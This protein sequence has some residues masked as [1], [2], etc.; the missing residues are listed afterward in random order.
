MW[1]EIDIP[2]LPAVLR[3]YTHVHHSVL[4]ICTAA[5]V[6]ALDLTAG[7]TWVFV[8][9]SITDDM[10]YADELVRYDDYGAI[11]F[12][13]AY[14]PLHGYPTEDSGGCSDIPVGENPST[15]DRLE[16]DHSTDSLLVRNETDPSDVRLSVHPFGASDSNWATAGFSYDGNHLTVGSLERILVFRHGSD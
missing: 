16:Y 9:P 10:L 8:A 6:F 3:A 11:V 4:F 1:K 14:Y 7:P 5:G 12:R 15:H 13:E 2:P